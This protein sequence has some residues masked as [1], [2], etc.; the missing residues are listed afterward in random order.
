[1]T[2]Q[3]VDQARLP[4]AQHHH[5]LEGTRLR[6]VRVGVGMN[7]ADFATH[8]GFSPR[9]Y[10]NWERGE[11]EMPSSLLRILYETYHVDPV[12]ILVG[13]GCLDVVHRNKRASLNH[14]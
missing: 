6:S 5:I 11:R 4:Q 2:L 14:L 13:P 12:W 8:L 3:V 9:A 1:V 10:A 7:Q